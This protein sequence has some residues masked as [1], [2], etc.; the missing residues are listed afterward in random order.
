MIHQRY[1]LS[2]DT[3][4]LCKGKLV[5]GIAATWGEVTGNIENQTDLVSYISAHGGGNAEWGSI[6]GSLPDQTDLMEYLDRFATTAWV[7]EQ[8]YLTSASLTGYATQSWVS[9]QGYLVSDDLSQYATRQ[10]VTGRGYVTESWISSQGYYKF[11]SLDTPVS[12]HD[13]LNDPSF[14]VPSE[15]PWEFAGSIIGTEMYDLYI[16]GFY[17]VEFE[18]GV[19]YTEFGGLH[20]TPYE[21]TWYTVSPYDDGEGLQYTV[22]D[23][24][25]VKQNDLDAYLG[26]YAT[27]S[28][29]SSRYALN[30]DL[31][32]LASRVT[33]LE[34]NYGDAVTITNNIL[35]V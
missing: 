32:A 5:P 25:F 20:I 17:P 28:W 23:I 30:S 11:G 33:D 34:T 15:F 35:G 21:L 6:S 22:K 2:S 10:W 3:L 31:A 12:T 26:S 1:E 27:K 7:S 18:P 9:S 24:P 19:E 16:G 13:Y 4:D 14:S 8:N 29:V